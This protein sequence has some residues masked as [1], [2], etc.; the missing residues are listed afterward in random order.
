[1]NS[2]EGYSVKDLKQWLSEFPDD[3]IVVTN[4]D[5]SGYDNIFCPEIISVR[6]EEENNEYDGIYQIEN[7]EVSESFDVVAIFRDNM[8]D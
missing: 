1:M 6:F 4:G 7:E 3:M 5:R 8:R 2:T